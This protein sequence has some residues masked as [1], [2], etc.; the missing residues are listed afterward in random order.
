M[1]PVAYYA[2]HRGSTKAEMLV[3]FLK[4]VLGACQNGGLHLVAVCDMATNNVKAMKLLGST[5]ESH[6]FSFKIKQ[7]QKY[8]PH[9]S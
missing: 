7:L 8:D 2:P 3:Q 9:T 4:E 6:S 5:G 1:Q